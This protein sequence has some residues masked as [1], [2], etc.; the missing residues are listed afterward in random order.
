MRGTGEPT[1]ARVPRLRVLADALPLVHGA[2]G[3]YPT[4]QLAALGERGDVELHVVAS[5]A[6][7]DQLARSCPQARVIR[8]PSR[9]LP[10]RWAW[11]QLVL[12]RLASDYD[13][14]YSMGGFAVFAARVPQVVLTQ[15]PHHYGQAARMYAR[16]TWGKVFRARLATERWLARRSVVRAERTVV[17]SDYL[18]AQL[19]S[20]LGARD[21]VRVLKKASPRSYEGIPVMPAG[22]PEEH[23]RYVLTVGHDYPQKDWDGLIGTFLRFD[24]LP[25]LVIA[26]EPR[27]PARAAELRVLLE[28]HPQGSKIHLLGRVSDPAELRALYENA[29]CFV[30]HSRF[31]AAPNAPEEAAAAGVPLVASDIG[32]HT[33]LLGDAAVY[34]T[35]GDAEGLADAVR[36][37]LRRPPVGRLP[38]RTWQENAEELARLLHEVASGGSDHS[39][40]SKK[41]FAF[42]R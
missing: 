26:G 12:P 4:N 41:N 15:N 5:G 37:A 28:R 3:T 6:L 13:V 27:S 11:E 1:A 9:P 21:D 29:A 35:M 10:A 32:P 23:V 7:A 2:L 25:A 30:A 39:S 38:R 8:Q 24:D 31:E 42:S 34:Y 16:V 33:E 36:T 40:S 20:D 17:V 22:A 18:R 14:I 19:E